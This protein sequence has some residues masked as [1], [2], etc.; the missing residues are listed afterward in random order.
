[1]KDQID[2]VVCEGLQNDDKEWHLFESGEQSRS[3]SATCSGNR[4]EVF[5]HLL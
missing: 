1:V 2:I 5:D 3:D 4:L